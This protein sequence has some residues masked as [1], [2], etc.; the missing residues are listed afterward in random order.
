[1]AGTE[2][3]AFQLE[4]F[5]VQLDEEEFESRLKAELPSG[6]K[7]ALWY[8]KSPGLLRK[9][10]TAWCVVLVQL[11]EAQS[12]DEVTEYLAKV[13][14]GNVKEG[15]LQRMTFPAENQTANEFVCKKYQTLARIETRR[16]KWRVSDEVRSVWEDNG[17]GES[18]L[19]SLVKKRETDSD[20]VGSKTKEE[21]EGPLEVPRG[22]Y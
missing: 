6:A 13:V 1:M 4:Y 5:R 12:V 3:E 18:T 21:E 20:K 8:E 16:T 7:Y 9:G 17:D 11:G 2:C 10:A 15:V 19:I 14:E 22:S